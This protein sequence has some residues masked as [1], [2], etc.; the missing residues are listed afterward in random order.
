MKLNI[1]IQISGVLGLVV[2]ELDVQALLDADLHLDGVVHLGVGGQGVDEQVHLLG[3]VRQPPHH[4]NPEKI[5]SEKHF[6]KK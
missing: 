3:H 6:F 1:L 5:P 4:R 2:F